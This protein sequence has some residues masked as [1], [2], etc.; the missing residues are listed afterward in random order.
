MSAADEEV[1]VRVAGTGEPSF[2]QAGGADGDYVLPGTGT[3]NRGDR[4]PKPQGGG[5]G[6]GR[7]AADSGGGEDAFEFTLTREEF[8]DCFFEELELPRLA[9]TELGEAMLSKPR[10][11]GFSIAG[12]PTALDV[13]RTMRNSLARRVA[14]RRPDREELAAAEQ[15]VADAVAAGDD[16]RLAAARAA[17][18]LVVRRTARIPFIDPIDVRYARHERV[19]LPAS[20][21]VMFCL[22]DVSG[23]MT[24][25]MKGLAKRFFMLLHLFLERKYERVHVVFIRHTERAQEVDEDTFFRSRETGGTV[26]SSA[27][28]EMLRVQAERFPPSAFN[29]YVAQASDGDNLHADAGAVVEL[30]GAHPAAGALL[31]LCGDRPGRGGA[32]RHRPRAGDQPVGHLPRHRRRAARRNWPCAACPRCATCGA[33]SPSCSA[34]TAAG[35]RRHDPAVR[36]RRVG[37]RQARRHLPRL[38]G[39]RLGELGLTPYPSQIEVITSEQMLDAYSSVGLP[40]MYRHWS[41]GKR[42]ARDELLY[43]AGMQSLAYEIVINSNP[44]IAYLMEENTMTMQALVIAHAC[45]GHNHFFRNNHLFRQWTDADGILDYL[46]FARRFVAECEERH[47]LAAVERILDA[48]TRCRARACTATCGASGGW[49]TRRT[50]ARERAEARGGDLQPALEHRARQRPR[51]PA[52]ARGGE[53]GEGAR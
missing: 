4:I 41:F 50:R 52:A 23:S 42:F 44:C 26:V 5:G 17:L 24:E 20:D 18:D 1:K 2:R 19:R 49:P 3:L 51:R 15:E 9:R 16:A 39:D 22:M 47:G 11:A 27:L 46:A 33:C 38:R 53:R 25:H 13:R 48:R 28:T 30:M 8:L 31:R 21:A 36:R 6:R 7:E 12:Q 10:R 40:L 34:R 37:L 29:I 14:L 43:R 32:V 35:A 45:F